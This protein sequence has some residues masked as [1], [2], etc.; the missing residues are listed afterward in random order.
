[1]NTNTISDIIKNL[2]S[3]NLTF[4]SL[5]EENNE[6]KNVIETQK[7]K[8]HELEEYNKSFTT[9]SLIVAAKN[10]NTVLSNEL[11]LLKK[12]LK[13]YENKT[14]LSKQENNINKNE[15]QFI[16]KTDHSEKTN[17]QPHKEQVEE[18][19]DEE[20]EEVEE[21]DDDDEDDEDEEEEEQVEE[22]EEQ[23]KVEEEKVEEEE[24]DDD[25]DDEEEDEEDE[26]DE[27]V[28]EETIDGKTYFVS[29]TDIVYD[30]IWNN[31]EWDIGD[32]IGKFD[33]TKL[34][35]II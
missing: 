23:E 4:Q 32:V 6:L 30:R 8:I 5:V 35:I 34:Q 28:Y 22:E 27:E 1:M 11:A 12:R 21:E 19:E 16:V 25:D 26:E 2:Q 29:E 18:D 14:M 9:V 31:D 7:N 3:H 20:E 24:V 10:E 13:Y 15:D 33:R 17:Q